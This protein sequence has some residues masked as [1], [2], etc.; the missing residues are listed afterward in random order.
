MI[1]KG[2]YIVNIDDEDTKTRFPLFEKPVGAITYEHSLAERFYKD[3][4]A[5]ENLLYRSRNS[6]YFGTIRVIF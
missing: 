3:I 5:Y 2:L 4:D 1:N 6:T